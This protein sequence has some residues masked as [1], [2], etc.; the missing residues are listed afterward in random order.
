MCVIF[1]G[2]DSIGMVSDTILAGTTTEA[3][4][5][6]IREEREPMYAG[7]CGSTG[8]PGTRADVCG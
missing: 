7:K 3:F 4:Q 1:V 2:K 8:Q 6:N 5:S